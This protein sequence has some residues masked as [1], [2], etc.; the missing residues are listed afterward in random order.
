MKSMTLTPLLLGLLAAC[1]GDDGGGNP[2]KLWLA[3]DGSEIKVKLVEQEPV[4]Y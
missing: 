1:G 4:P 3:L 2:S